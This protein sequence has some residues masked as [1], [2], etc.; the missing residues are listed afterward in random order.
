MVAAV[1]N[2]T[3][4]G[5]SGSTVTIPFTSAAN[6]AAAQTALNFINSLITNGLMAQ[7]NISPNGSPSVLA[8]SALPGFYPLT[9]GVLV[10]PTT[11]GGSAIALPFG[12]ADLISNATV[13]GSPGAPADSIVLGQKNVITVVGAGDLQYINQSKNATVFLTNGV[14]L[15]NIFQ[16]GLV[17]GDATGDA[18]TVNVDSQA[19]IFDYGTNG[20]TTVNAFGGSS[21]NIY[22]GAP[23]GTGGGNV[24]VHAQAGSQTI[25]QIVN[26]ASATVPAMTITGVS[27]SNTTYYEGSG[28]AFIDPGAGN[29]TIQGALNGIGGLGPLGSVTLF[30]GSANLTPDGSLTGSA[31]VNFGQGYFAGGSG[32]NNYLSTTTV[33]GSAT[34]IGGGNGDQL[35][36]FGAKELLIAGAGSETLAGTTDTSIGGSYFQT[37]GG[38]AMVYG[39]AQGGNSF[40]LGAGISNVVGSTGDATLAGMHSVANLYSLVGNGGTDIINDFHSIADAL[41][42]TDQF[43]LT[44]SVGGQSFVSANY[45]LANDKTNPFF[46][47]AGTQVTLSDGTTLDF[48]NSKVTKADFT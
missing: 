47:I 31:R 32:G 46:G 33:T 19:A 30:G 16:Q 28:R 3:V 24:V 37:G 48:F 20:S 25:L 13:S 43:S 42:V 12:S 18:A 34:L 17:G 21:V 4:L 40:F 38:N 41:S 6:A 7:Q 15:G 10:S 5:A 29:I 22:R 2:V 11:T 35:F 8:P 39:N 1:T 23:G 44:K 36:A 9:G 27:G 14:G 26:N 45:Y